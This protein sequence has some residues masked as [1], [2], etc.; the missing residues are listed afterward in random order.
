MLRSYFCPHAEVF[1]KHTGNKGKDGK[2]TES[3]GGASENK[4][5]LRERRQWMKVTLMRVYSTDT[6]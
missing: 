3:R 4:I 5:I 6:I 1:S 2:H